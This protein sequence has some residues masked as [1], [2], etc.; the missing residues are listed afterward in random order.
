MFPAHPNNM[1]EH[2]RAAEPRRLLQQHKRQCALAR[3]N[4]AGDCG[5]CKYLRTEIAAIAH[6]RYTAP[7]VPRLVEPM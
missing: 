7:V 6:G 5:V 4:L 1:P 3:F 2:M